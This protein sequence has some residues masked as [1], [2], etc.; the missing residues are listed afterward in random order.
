LRELVV[1]TG[2]DNELDSATEL[3]TIFAPS[4]QAFE[5]YEELNDLS[6]PD[7]ARDLLLRHI[8]RGSYSTQNLFALDCLRMQNTDPT[9]MP[10]NDD[11]TIGSNSVP[12]ATPDVDSANG[13]IHAINQVLA[14]S[15]DPCPAP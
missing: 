13:Y 9:L 4:N 7:V 11:E 1:L 10:I 15:T 5:E 12:I 8:A 14:P 6:E 2:L 3:R